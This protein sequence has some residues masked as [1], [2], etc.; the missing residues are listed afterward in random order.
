MTADPTTPDTVIL[1]R[2]LPAS[3]ERVFQAWAD[4]DERMQWD[5]PGDDWVIEE[6]QQDFR[7]D[8]IERSRFGPKDNPTAESFG[9]YLYIEPARRIVSAGV[10]RSA[11][12]GT[13]SSTTMMT[14][15]F[16]ADGEGTHLTLIDQSVYLGWGETAEMRKSGWG[17]IL[18]KLEGY[19]GN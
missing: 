19:L 1:E 18:T 3:P 8:G 17:S 6:F 15:E 4:R 11:E 16:R 14:L 10:M 5:V 7:V 13:V 2:R 12:T 9:R